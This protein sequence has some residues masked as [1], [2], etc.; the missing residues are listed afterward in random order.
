M[1][2]H[3][4]SNIALEQAEELGRKYESIVF[5]NGRQYVIVTTSKL[6]EAD[7]TLK[8]AAEETFVTDSDIQ[9]ASKQ[10]QSATRKVD[11]GAVTIGGDTHNTVVITG[12]CSVE[13]EE[14]IEQ[15]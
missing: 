7:A 2:V 5:N 11:I 3:L 12:P 13:S 15:A 8:E 4:K 10:Y 9:L 14:Q 1:I 6:K